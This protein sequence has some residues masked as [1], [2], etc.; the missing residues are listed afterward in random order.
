MFGFSALAFATF[1]NVAEEKWGTGVG[2]SKRRGCRQGFIGV[3]ENVSALL[4]AC[5]E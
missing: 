4:R 2:M 5:V 3:C 1:E